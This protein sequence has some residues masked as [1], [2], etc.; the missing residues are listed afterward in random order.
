MPLTKINNRSLSGVLTSGQVPDQQPPVGSVVQTVQDIN[1]TKTSTTPSANGD[2]PQCP[3][4]VTITPTSTSNKIL[5]MFHGSWQ[6]GN[7]NDVSFHL[8][9]DGTPVGTSNGAGSE[10]AAAFLTTGQY[11]F[12]SWSPGPAVS[13]NYLDSPNTTSAITYTVKAMGIQG[14]KSS[15]NRALPKAGSV[16]SEEFTWGGTTANDAESSCG[17]MVMICQEI[18]G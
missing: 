7:G 10:N 17:N 4:S 18:K 14:T 12:N 9:R 3:A 16:S 6:F 5:I 1:T 8:L 13:F 11:Q 2:A 15:T